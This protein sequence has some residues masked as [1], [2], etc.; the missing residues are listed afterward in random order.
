MKLRIL[1]FHKVF[2]I[3]SEAV[4]GEIVQRCSEE[5]IFLKSLHKSQENTCGRVSFLNKVAFVR[6][7]KLIFTL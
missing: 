6:T 7:I 2:E 4:R 3:N 5:R 1:D